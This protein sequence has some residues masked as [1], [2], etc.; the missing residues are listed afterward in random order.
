[1][2]LRSVLLPV[3]LGPDE[4]DHLARPDLGRDAVQDR[5]AVPIAEADLVEDQG[6]RPLRHALGRR[7]CP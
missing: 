2:R 1:M 3:P 6:A 5:L 7:A 4:G